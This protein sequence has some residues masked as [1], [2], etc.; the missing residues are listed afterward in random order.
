MTIKSII[1]LERIISMVED[2]A[3]TADIVRIYYELQILKKEILGS[4]DE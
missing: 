4:S 3:E 2:M 1:E